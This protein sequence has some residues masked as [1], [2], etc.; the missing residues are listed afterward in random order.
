MSDPG[1]PLP[2]FN[3]YAQPNVA[4]REPLPPSPRRSSGRGSF[5]VLVVAFVVLAG[6]VAFLVSRRDDPQSPGEAVRDWVMAVYDEDADRICDGLAASNVEVIESG[7]RSCEE[8]FEETFDVL[9]EPAG[10]SGS[11]GDEPATDDPVDL[12]QPIDLAGRRDPSIEILD[13]EIEGD[14]AAVR[15]QVDDSQT[16]ATRPLILVREGG[17]WKID[18]DG[19]ETLDSPSRSCDAEERVVKTAVEAYRAQNGEDPADA[20]ALVDARMLRELPEHAEVAGDGSVRMT[21]E[22]A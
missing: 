9:D 13:V 20:Q 16:G 4:V 6:A 7:G 10:S 14:R 3:P 5:V 12:L 17:R 8:Q 19:G 15:V 2:P 18:F 11:G 1:P 21:G 22:C